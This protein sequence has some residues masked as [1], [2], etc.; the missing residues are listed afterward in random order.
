VPR[1]RR[2]ELRRVV[3]GREHSAINDS[4][5]RATSARAT[6][7]V[8][9]RLGVVQ[10]IVE[11]E[12]A[13]PAVADRVWGR[14]VEMD[15]VRGR[16]VEMDRTSCRPA[17]MDRVWGR[18]AE[19]D[20]VWGRRAEMDRVWGRRAEMDRAWGR[21]A[22]MDRAWGRRAEMDR[23]WGRRAEIDRAWGRQAEMDR[24][25]ARLVTPTQAR[26]R[27]PAVLV[28]VPPRTGLQAHRV[29]V[30]VLYRTRAP[31][32][33]SGRARHRPRRLPV[34][35]RTEPHPPR[36]KLAVQSPGSITAVA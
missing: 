19:M 24:A 8:L 35:A 9:L 33:H 4:H 11:Q 7:P 18:R 5:R 15:R 34:P 6:C 16:P 20:R 23:A 26:T 2:P 12:A 22:E 25:W 32:A 3:M 36:I 14:P 21:R 29:R 17:E 28:A 1:D 31:R 27:S 30:L 10:R 13:R